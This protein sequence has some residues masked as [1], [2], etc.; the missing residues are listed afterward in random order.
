MKDYKMLADVKVPNLP[1]YKMRI[2]DEGCPY[3]SEEIK[4]DGIWER[5]ETNLTCQI[6]KPND[7]VLDIGANIGYYTL[8]TS[9]LVGSEGQVIAFEPESLNFEILEWNINK[10]GHENTICINAGVSNYTGETR[11][12]LTPYN[13]GGHHL[14]EPANYLETQIVQI[15]SIDEFLKDK[16][17]K[18]DFIKIDAQGA[19][20]GIL[21]G[22][23]N[24]LAINCGNLKVIIE[25]APRGSDSSI[26]GLDLALETIRSSFKK[27]MLI[28]E[29]EMSV[30]EV[31]FDDIVK[32]GKIGLESEKNVFTNFLCFASNDAYESV[33]QSL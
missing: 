17:K 20:Q 25:F 27:F 14:H 32:I 10:F 28:S 11:L 15:T 7:T 13:P 22:M 16:S 12:H 9:K 33:K 4:K 5:C 31:T 8:L 3:L 29:R 19:E 24:T 2:Y 1:P 26:G 21:D 30:S 18:V 23:K 6:V